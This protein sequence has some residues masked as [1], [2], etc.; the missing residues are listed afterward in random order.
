M[1]GYSILG[2][3]AGGTGGVTPAWTPTDLANLQFWFDASDA[4]KMWTDAGTTLVSSDGQAVYRLGDKSGNGFHANQSGSSTLRPLYKTAYQNG[5]DAL[6]FDGTDDYLALP[7]MDVFATAACVFVAVNST[8]NGTEQRP[9]DIQSPD[10]GTNQCFFILRLY[11]VTNEVGAFGYDTASI[12]NKV[13]VDPAGIGIWGLTAAESGNIY[14][15]NGA[16]PGA[17]TAISTFKAIA[18]ET[19]KGNIGANRTGAGNFFKG[20]WC[21]AIGYSSV[22]SGADITNIVNYLGRWVP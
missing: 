11:Q 22:P 13:S 8:E 4:T 5:L 12:E 15:Y 18:A 16:T 20:A 6:L 7:L 21:E 2:F 14:V 17:G 19:G 1:F 3:G 9:I 10:T